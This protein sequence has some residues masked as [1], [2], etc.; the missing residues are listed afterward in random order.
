MGSE[1][2]MVNSLP[3]VSDETSIPF[4]FIKNAGTNFSIEVE[5][6]E[7]LPS[8]AIV[9]LRDIKLG[10][11][12]N[13]SQIPTYSFTSSL[14]DDPLRFQIHFG[15]VGINDQV[16]PTSIIAY[17]SDG[18]LF[19]ITP[20][21]ATEVCVFNVQGQLL[22]KN[23]IPGTNIQYLPMNLPS[24]VYFARL[25]NKEEIKTVKFIVKK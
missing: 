5:G 25:T 16:K 22:Y 1:N 15:T 20:A 4:N 9:Y 3:S 12:H 17:Y 7:S 24:G 21:K 10:V 8:S 23:S 11:E 14:G 13:V 2:L 18:K 6:L 19:V